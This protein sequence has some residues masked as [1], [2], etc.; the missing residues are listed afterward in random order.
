MHTTTTHRSR[1]ESG[2]YDHVYF[3]GD[4]HGDPVV[5]LE[6]AVLT[7][8][9]GTSDP[10]VLSDLL[11]IHRTFKPEY[12]TTHAASLGCSL[13]LQHLHWRKGARTLLVF[14]GDLMD[15]YRYGNTRQSDGSV[16]MP[17]RHANSMI[18]LSRT[19]GHVRIANMAMDAERPIVETLLR[20]Q[21]EARENG[22]D[23]VWVLGN[24]DLGNVIGSI[25]CHTYASLDQCDP[26]DS[27]RFGSQRVQWVREHL[28][29]MG[30]V[31]LC[32]IDD[33]L[34]CH[35]GLSPEFLTSLT[36]GDRR[37]DN[38]FETPCVDLDR[39]NRLYQLAILDPDSSERQQVQSFTRKM[40]GPTWHRPLEGRRPWDATH[41]SWVYTQHG[42]TGTRVMPKTMIVAHSYLEKPLSHLRPGKTGIQSGRDIAAR[43]KVG[44]DIGVI[45]E[46]YV[47]RPWSLLE[48]GMV[49]GVDFA[50]S[51]SFNTGD[52]YD[53]ESFCSMAVL[54]YR[55]NAVRSVGHLHSRC[56]PPEILDI[57]YQRRTFLLDTG[58]VKV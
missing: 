39:I 16:Y 56:I 57:E 28:L 49:F 46:S 15:N 31:V 55:N 14:V 24:H 7:G 8:S 21:G 6:T 53:R 42:I 37:V 17:Y 44:D 19:S 13:G 58:T 25:A 3:I 48:P 26:H 5:L 52:T 2:S 32:M 20:L 34:I 23:I 47:S 35:G 30:A 27:T 22:G 50:L 10:T 4:L 9:F 51:R 33:V 12:R 40:T 38:A 45:N 41:L 18:P 29:H 11:S 1:F 54:E 43:W 36:R